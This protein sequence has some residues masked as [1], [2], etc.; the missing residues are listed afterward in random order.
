MSRSRS[1]CRRRTAGQ[2]HR[3]VTSP[4]LRCVPGL[5]VTL[6]RTERSGGR[7][8]REFHRTAIIMFIAF[9]APLMRLPV[10]AGVRLPHSA[11]RGDTMGA[12]M[13]P[14][15][16]RAFLTAATAAIATARFPILGA[17]DRI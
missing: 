15:E 7:E 11:L 13:P 2:A 3:P 12:T 14:L 1:G 6:F 9:R 16:R 5:A 8:G 10:N 4:R 17:N